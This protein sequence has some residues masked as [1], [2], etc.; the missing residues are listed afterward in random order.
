MNSNNKPPKKV[1][2]FSFLASTG[3]TKQGKMKARKG[4][5]GDKKAFTGLEAAI[6]LTAFIVVAAVFSYMVLGAGFFSTEKAK[7]VVHTGVETTTSSAELAGDVIGHGW[8]YITTG[9]NKTLGTYDNTSA[10]PYTDGS[11]LPKGQTTTAIHIHNITNTTAS[12]W[13]YNVSI[14]YTNDAG[15]SNVTYFNI[16]DSMYGSGLNDTYNTTTIT[17]KATDITNI[18]SSSNK[19]VSW[20]YLETVATMDYDTYYAVNLNEKNSTYLTVVE[21]QLELTAGQEPLDMNKVVLSYSDND[22]YVPELT[23][24][25]RGNAHL[26]N[27]TSGTSSG[28]WNY[29]LATAEMGDTNMLDPNEKMNVIVAIPSPG[30]VAYQAFQI[31]L[32]PAQGGALTLKKTPPGAIRKTRRL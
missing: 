11:E 27:L 28:D 26:G 6:V 19:S 2:V 25:N 1:E 17:D 8:L 30:A 20:C 32:K 7:E 29:T 5:I 15:Q 16:T 10:T 24:T 12:G 22:T 18:N 31:D 9:T 13:Y 3:V 23:Y 4:I 14:Y 21:F